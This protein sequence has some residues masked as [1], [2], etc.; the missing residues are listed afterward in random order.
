MFYKNFV[1]VLPQ[2]FLGAVSGFSGQKLFNDIL[3]QSY[4]VFLTFVPIMVFA[5]LDQDVS[6]EASL[7]HP[8]LYEMGPGRFYMNFKV[9]LGWIASGVWHAAVV[10]VVPYL[11]MSN[12]NITH[13]DGKANDLWLV[14]TVIFLLAVIVVNLQCLLETCFVNRLTVFGIAFSLF[15]WFLLQAYFSGLITGA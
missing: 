7:K 11:V 2:Y 8:E 12:G 1:I 14:G 6:K 5:V 9:S 4:N 15:W 13:S 10:F 3:Y